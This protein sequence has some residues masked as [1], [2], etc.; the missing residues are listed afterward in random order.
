[1]RQVTKQVDFPCKEHYVILEFDTIYV[2]DGYGSANHEPIIRYFYFDNEK[3]WI[4]IIK[5]Y[6]IENKINFKAFKAKP[7]MITTNVEVSV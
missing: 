6:K 5:A 3:D 7:A 2:D 4:D 1:M